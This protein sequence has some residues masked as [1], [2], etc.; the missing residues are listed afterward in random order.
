MNYQL[1]DMFFEAGREA[2][3]AHECAQALVLAEAPA[4]NLKDRD[5]EVIANAYRLRAALAAQSASPLRTTGD[6]DEFLLGCQRAVLHAYAFQAIPEPPDNYTV[7]F[8]KQMSAR[9]AGLLMALDKTKPDRA[10]AC[11]EALRDFWSSY[12]VLAQVTDATLPPGE[13]QALLGAASP[14]G[15]CAYLFPAAPLADEMHVPG[16]RYFNEAITIF[17]EK[18]GDA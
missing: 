5:N 13:V 6:D 15:L 12:R 9:I 18:L 7:A 4:L 11:C 17:N 3:A 10:L 8:Y 16:S 1:G 2:E 14:E